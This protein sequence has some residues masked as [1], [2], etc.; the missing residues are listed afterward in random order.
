MGTAIAAT[1]VRHGLNVVICDAD[2]QVLRTVAARIAREADAAL[3]SSR[4]AAMPGR[5]IITGD[6]PAVAAC[7]LVL[8]SIVESQVA[9]QRLLAEI[10]PHLGSR[11]MIASNTSTIPIAALAA[12]L[13]NSSRF[14]GLHFFHPVRRRPLVEIV[15]GP[16]TT[17]Q[18]V[19]A[20]GSFAA[21][22]EKV[23]LVVRDGP[24]FLVNRLLAPYLG[25]AMELLLE[26]AA[27]EQIERAA[28]G[29][30]M[31][32]GPLR[33]ADE[34]GLDT[35]WLG[36]RVLWQ[37]FPDRIV[38]SPLLIA[39]YKAQR[40]G[41]KVGRGFFVY[42]QGIGTDEPGCADPEVEAIISVW[43]K[44]RRS[45]TAG[46]ITDRLL[47]PMV[48]EATRLLEEKTVSQPD[49]IDQ[50]TVLGLGFPPARGGLLRWADERGPQRLVAALRESAHLGAAGR[51]YATA[52]EDGARGISVPCVPQC[53]VLLRFL[54]TCLPRKRVK[55]C[56]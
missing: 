47:L 20:A 5:I 21:S 37:A 23:S 45:F 29:F 22:I 42:R 35:L 4:A 48:L 41:R 50:G 52:I 8:E 54:N 49:E 46:Q 25:E 6:L 3:P 28:T 30:G 51:A 18:T 56:G 33:L 36:G 27:I 32:L 40:L 44:R 17:D 53:R 34:I 39:M 43:A 16:A 10:E 19:A 15:R 24:G 14:C 2:P 26:G 31:A 9:K 55:P 13:R 7:D 38:P 1:A 11:A 12:T